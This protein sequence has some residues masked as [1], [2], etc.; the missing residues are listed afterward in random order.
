M[1]GSLPY[2]LAVV[3]SFLLSCQTGVSKTY[4]AK[5]GNSMRGIYKFSSVTGFVFVLMMIIKNFATG[6]NFSVTTFSFVVA[7]ILALLNA[8]GIIFMFAAFKVGTV[9]MQVLF[10]RLG[11]LLL[12]TVFGFLFQNEAVTLGKIICIVLVIAALVIKLILRKREVLKRHIFI[13]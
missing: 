13:I 2:I 12:P 8:V 7:F 1:T 3:A 11:T 6:D 4:S 10:S 5:Y 9:S